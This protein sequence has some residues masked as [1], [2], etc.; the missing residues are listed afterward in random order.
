MEDNTVDI[1]VAK[2][3]E[4]FEAR[5]AEKAKKEAELEAI[6]KE[7]YEKGVEE[8][9]K[10]AKTWVEEKAGVVP[11]KKAKP[12]SG[13]QKGDMDTFV[14]F[15]KTG[16]EIAAKASLEQ[17]KDGERGIGVDEESRKALSSASGAAGEYLV[18][19][20]FND[21][22]IP[23]RDAQSFVRKMGPSIFPT[24][25]KVVD[26]PAENTSLTKFSRTAELGTY[27]TNDPAFAQNQVTV[28]KWTKMTR[29]SEEILEDNTAGLVEWYSNALGRAMAQTEAYYVAVGSGTNQHEGIF[30]G[31]DTDA[32][33]YN[34]DTGMDSDFAAPAPSAIW[35]HY[36]D[37]GEGYREDA[38][39]LASG[40]TLASILS[41]RSSKALEWGS[42]DLLSISGGQIELCGR[43]FY[44]QG[45]IPAKASGVGF[46]AF[47]C[48]FYYTLVERKGLTV[49]R[50][51]YL[52][53]ASGEI[54]VF[55]SFRQSGK[56]TVEEAWNIGVGA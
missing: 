44:T 25:L 43:P 13:G 51:P 49:A 45:D 21:M 46:I 30:E 36:F 34:T 15:I 4:V 42:A 17:V 35:N 55:A 40:A 31:G 19:D 52:Y 24:N 50:N 56:V 6:R 39:W 10:K 22:I 32:F 26:L 27:S 1:A 33:T 29:F 53:Q 23:K 14:Y 28:Q 8:G 2:A 3:L 7:A 20:D 12:G 11:M 9:E 48:P 38:V 5:Q 37:L 18:P 16:D 41:F 54:A 47:G